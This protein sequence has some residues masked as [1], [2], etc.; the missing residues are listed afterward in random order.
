MERHELAVALEVAETAVDVIV[1]LLYERSVSV[2]GLHEAA[3]IVAHD[4]I[5]LA[6]HQLGGW[7]ITVG[8]VNSMDKD[9]ENIN[10]MVDLQTKF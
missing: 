10:Q 2:V 5:T 3:D 8:V 4:A 1:G 9:S 7:N 6:V